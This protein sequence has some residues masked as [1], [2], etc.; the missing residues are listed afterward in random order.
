MVKDE[1]GLVIDVSNSE[2]SFENCGC[3][4]PARYTTHDGRGSC[5]KYGRC[6]TYDELY[7]ANKQLFNDLR[8]VLVQ[9]KSVLI[10]REGTT[11]YNEAVDSIKSIA[12]QNGFEL[13]I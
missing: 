12:T 10:Y 7:E 3:G 11:H 5:S 1:H 2:L 9:T 8:Y 13:E 4:K 6:P